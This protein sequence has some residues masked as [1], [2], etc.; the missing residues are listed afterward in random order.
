MKKKWRHWALC[1]VLA[2]GSALGASLLSDVRF[3]Q[4]LNLKAYDA[5]FVVRY[6]L[7]QRPSIPNIVLLLA[8]QKA[9]D[10]FPELRLFWHQHYANVI[11]AAG[12]A[13]AK[14]I[15]LDLAFGIPVEK[16]EPDY[17]RL[18]GEAVSTSPVPVVC[19]SVT[20]LNTNPDAARIPINMLSAALGLAGFVNLTI[21]SDDFVRRQELIEAPSRGSSDAAPAHSLALRIAE[22]FA[23]SDAE[24]QQGK[25][26][27]QGQPIPIAA[28]RSIAINYA[29]PPDTFP[30]VSLAD[31]ENA[32]KA[33]NKD[34]LRKWVGGKI[35]LVGTDSLD[36]RR[37]T[38]FFTLFSGTKWL[39]PGVE[40]HA[41]TVRTLL[42]RSYLV[43]A[44]QWVLVLA[45]LL[46]T[47]VTVA[48]VT[49]FA[50][51]RAVGFVALEVFAILVATHLLFEWGF[52]LSTSEVLLATSVSLV[53]SLIYRYAT[54]ETRGNLFHRAVSVFVGKQLA[55]SL[56]ESSEAIALSGK[57]M[58]VTILFTD[59]RGFTAFTEQVSEE[60][61]P[62]VVVQLLND[63]MATMVGIIVMYHGQV[64]KFIG[65]GILA[66]FS[67]DDEGSEPG[68][69]ALRAVRCATRMVTTPSRFETGAGIHTGP[70]VVG[71]VGS[72]DKMEYTVL[73]D[74]VNLASRL[75][76][77]NKEHHTKLLMTGTTRGRL[78]S[79]VETSH[80]GEAPVR[81]KALPIDL[82]TVTSL[83]KAPVNA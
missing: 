5:H 6:L 3:F 32:A 63:Y 54:E 70:A 19:A 82:Y 15:G 38:P 64:N 45:L 69:H 73:G 4:I 30:S 34:Q 56:E 48:I 9:L 42:T 22:K 78:G 68:D 46:T 74:T 37:D 75:E 47:M 81:G 51:G 14:V 26:V 18:L 28:D 41:N 39:T 49:S 7:G 66:V 13:G 72:A 83:V 27:F 77:L 80:L 17:D 50:A 16:Y 20:A 59:I 35:V 71:N 60:Q 29:G 57:R 31:F 44:P 65:D 25:L 40:I 79:L 1:A 43:P 36:D 33:G 61:G 58:E 21:D 55:S 12:Q 52:V 24:W 23:G 2:A 8:D 11:R 76:S 10:T 67:D 53:A 62:E